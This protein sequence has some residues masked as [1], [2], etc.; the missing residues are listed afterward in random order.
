[1]I[2]V[3]GKKMMKLLRGIRSS[4][5]EYRIYAKEMAAYGGL[6]TKEGVN[7]FV[8]GITFQPGDRRINVFCSCVKHLF[9]VYMLGRPDSA[10]KK[11]S[12][13]VYREL[14]ENAHAL[15]DK[16]IGVTSLHMILLHAE[17]ACMDKKAI[18][19]IFSNLH[20]CMSSGNEEV[21]DYAANTVSILEEMGF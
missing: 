20:R 12:N 19:G 15:S 2:D 7:E 1:M 10:A 18:S 9:V 17:S 16:K 11:F 3:S 14:F 5:D 21:W 4:G 8:D 13:Y 6:M